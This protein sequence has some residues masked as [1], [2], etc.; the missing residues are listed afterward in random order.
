MPVSRLPTRSD[1]S[2]L[3]ELRISDLRRI[4]TR[5]WTRQNLL[6]SQSLEQ[7]EIEFSVPYQSFEGH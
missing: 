3:C 6:E 5:K 1:G 4:S 7:Y 2:D